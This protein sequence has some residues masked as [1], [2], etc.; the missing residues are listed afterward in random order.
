MSLA[1]FSSPFIVSP[2]RQRLLNFLPTFPRRRFPTNAAGDLRR[3]DAEGG[4]ASIPQ[5]HGSGSSAAG[6]HVDAGR[7][8]AGPLGGPLR[9][10]AGVY[11]FVGGPCRTGGESGECESCHT[12]GWRPVHLHRLQCRRLYLPHRAHQRVWY[13]SQALHACI[14]L[15]EYT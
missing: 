3:T 8:P 5:V 2:R 1:S 4:T 7:P 6:H 14:C 12:P 10:P 13:V 9:R 11:G 15:T